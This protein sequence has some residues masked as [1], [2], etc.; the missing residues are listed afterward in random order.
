MPQSDGRNLNHLAFL[1]PCELS[2]SNLYTLINVRDIQL[3]S[4][5]DSMPNT[6]VTEE[7]DRNSISSINNQLE[8]KSHTH[9]THYMLMLSKSVHKSKTNQTNTMYSRIMHSDGSDI[10]KINTFSKY[11]QNNAQI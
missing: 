5:A 1:M 7:D 4:A 2:A 10:H 9:V 11:H 6:T 8:I 3:K